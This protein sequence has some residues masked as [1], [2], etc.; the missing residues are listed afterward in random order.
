M[1]IFLCFVF[2]TL[3]CYSYAQ[4]AQSSDP[5][6]Y[7]FNNALELYQKGNYSA[8]RKLFNDFIE[9][10]NQSVQ[11]QDAQ[12][13][14]AVAALKLFN[15]DG[16]FLLNDFIV[17]NPQ[18]PKSSLA[19]FELGD[20]YYNTKDYKNASKY[21]AFVEE[22][23]LDREYLDDLH[24]KQGYSHFSRKEFSEAKRYFSIVQKGNNEYSGAASYY[25]GYITLEEEKNYEE[26]IANLEKAGESS[27]YKKAVIPMIAKAYYLNE[28][29]E[30]LIE[31]SG[32][33][34]QG[35]G[36]LDFY[37]AE[38]YFHTK[39]Y[40]K[41]VT[42]YAKYF[43]STK[44]ERDASVFYRA[45]I[46]A[47]K[48]NDFKNAET[49]FE[50]AAE[51]KDSIAQNA[52]FY[53][54]KIYVDQENW[55]YAINAFRKAS[56]SNGDKLIR[57]EAKYNL[58]KLEYQAGRYSEAIDALSEYETQYPKGKF[59]NE[60][61]NLLS[62]S[63]LRT[64][65]YSKAISY[66]EGLNKRSDNINSVYQKVTFYQGVQFFNNGKFRQSV[67][68]FEK[69]IA[70]PY[71]N[72]VLVEAY[73]WSGEA[74]SIGKRY[75]EAEDDYLSA[76]RVRVS[77]EN[78]FKIRSHYGL[79]YSYYNQQ[80][81]RDALFHFQKY[82]E[83]AESDP[84][85]YNYDDALIRLAD[86]YYA[87]KGY[88]SSLDLYSQAI[89]EGNQQTD[90]AYFQRG[91]VNGILGNFDQALIDLD[92]VLERSNNAVLLDRA[93]FQK[94]QFEFEKGDYENAINS[95]ST[96][97]ENSTD[98]R[99]LGYA[100]LRRGL[101]YYNLER[102]QDAA[103]DYEQI[104]NQYPN[105]PAAD[106]A[107]LGLQEVLSRLGRNEELDRYIA[108]FKKANPGGTSLASVEYENAKSYYFNQR[109][110]EAIR[111]FDQFVDEYPE[112]SNVFE[113][114]FY[115]AESYYR[116]EKFDESIPYYEE[117]IRDNKT[118]R[119]NRAVLRLANIYE[120]LGQMEKAVNNFNLLSEVA[121]NK[122]DLYYAYSGLMQI[123]FDRQSYDSALIYADLILERANAFVNA[124][125]Q[126]L[127]FKGKIAFEK[128]DFELAT[129][130][131]L[132]VL[133]SAVDANGAEAQYLI[134][135]IYNLQGYYKQSISSLYDLNKNFSNN[136][137]W[138]GRSFLLI[139]DNFI[140]L[141]EF[142]QARET[143]N[144][145]IANSPLST[146]VFEGEK[147]LEYLDRIEQESR[148]IPE[149]TSSIEVDSVGIDNGNN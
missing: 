7:L 2:L 135:K 106:D 113:A 57:E 24:F 93:L 119:V 137:L 3:S 142:F 97:V 92:E 45:G 128:E 72:D 116:L 74:Y 38:S 95:F 43:E 132:E 59:L 68:L 81:Y 88:T 12:Y 33:Q 115:L 70:Y 62:T 32:S 48:S 98:V 75:N 47:Y 104:I 127:L 110:D 27:G 11:K 50:R 20:F 136:E 39:Q 112:N 9:V 109:Y 4:N 76:L 107:L 125:S 84:D 26:A 89:S 61:I 13:Y 144:S 103:K 143:L 118:V 145:L 147:K 42:S 86:C 87:N 78:E 31:Y 67:E 131:F 54:G 140:Q 63:Y 37:L 114:K 64:S 101:S 90:Y 5:D 126:A 18:H 94:A 60:A 123:Y 133:N 34:S 8:A 23:Q 14:K 108:Q 124:E 149:D 58:A 1:R 122:K 53:L 56:A 35:R 82:F 55:T 40:K 77:A 66:I 10:S 100:F 129:D 121:E 49:Y 138:L 139:A 16:E 25:T 36:D 71:S 44:S 19:Y 85:R 120:E 96:L 83:E 99:Y 105:H 41:A 134:A 17:N 52:S 21:F 30:R 102:N 46:S 117:V 79:G 65:N 146:I 148:A 141:E 28:D 29:Y 130:L 91:L 6:N 80:K 111:F 15:N 69:S 73:F 22:S 51:S